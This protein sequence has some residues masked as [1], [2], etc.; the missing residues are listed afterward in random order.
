[1]HGGV[2]G[3]VGFKPNRYVWPEMD[4]GSVTHMQFLSQARLF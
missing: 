2:K 1:M 4:A 3:F